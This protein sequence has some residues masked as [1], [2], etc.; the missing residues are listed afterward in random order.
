MNIAKQK[1]IAD[2]VLQKLEAIDPFCIVAGGAPRDWY[3]GKEASDIDVFVHVP[4]RTQKILSKQL[5]ALGFGVSSEK[6]GEDLPANYKMNPHLISVC[7][8]DNY[9]TPVQV[10]FMN[11]PT[12][13]S[14]IPMFALSI[15]K[16]WYKGEDI[17]RYK[18]K[19]EVQ[20]GVQTTKDFD[21]SVKFKSVFKCSD[22]YNN[23]HKYLKKILAKFP[24]YKYYESKSKFIDN[25]V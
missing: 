21:L 1:Q 9:D 20:T 3:F 24:D 6:R 18:S 7:N 8:I 17:Q 12:F 2:E 10:M 5:K 14:V 19:G 25:V 4:V 15:C 16:A 11:E 22:L 13:Q 23:E